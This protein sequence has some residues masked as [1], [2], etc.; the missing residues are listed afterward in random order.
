MAIASKHG[1]WQGW[2]SPSQQRKWV[3]DSL[4][5]DGKVNQGYL[6]VTM[7]RETLGRMSRQTAK[8]YKP[9]EARGRSGRGN[10][11]ERPGGQGRL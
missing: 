10:G 8:Y 7:S 2:V 4:V 11:R 1:R 9:A 5:K 6:G 3:T